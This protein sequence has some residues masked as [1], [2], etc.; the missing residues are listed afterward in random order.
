MHPWTE[1]GQPGAMADAQTLFHPR[2]VYT[3][4]ATLLTT[5]LLILPVCTAASR[6][7]VS[8]RL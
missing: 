6:K 5:H 2:T 1:E 3:G 8:T 4:L 7:L